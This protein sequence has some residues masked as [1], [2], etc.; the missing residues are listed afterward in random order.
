MKTLVLQLDRTEDA[1]SIRDKVAWG[2]AS[3]VLLVWPMNF[4]M[5]DRKFDLVAVKRICTTQGSRLGIICD[6]PAIITEA[7]ELQIP[8]FE[9]VNHAMR[10]AWDRRNRR[11]SGRPSV[12]REALDMDIEEL[13]KGKYSNREFWSIH[14]KSKIP[15]FLLAILAVFSIIIFLYPSAKITIFSLG[16]SSE[17]KIDFR[18]L[19][20]EGSDLTPGVLA[21]TKKTIKVDGETTIPTSGSLQVPDLKAGGVVTMTNLTSLDVSI[22]AGTIIQKP[23]NPPVRY[24]ILKMITIPAK[25]TTI[26]IGIE[27]I[28]PG[29]KG[30]S[31]INSITRLDG[32][33][34]LLVEVSN[35][36]PV[37]GGLEKTYQAV[38][39]DD[40]LRAAEENQKI[41][42]TQAEA[43]FTK[44]LSVQE[45][46]LPSSIHIVK[47]VEQSEHPG[48]EQVGVLL[49]LKQTVE[50]SVL[51]INQNDMEKQ[52]E[53]ILNVNQPV[54]GW[55]STMG[56]PV[57]IKILSQEFDME[58]GS[59]I[60]Q[61]AASKMFAPPLDTN[62]IR[63]Q[64]TGKSKAMAI[65]IIER[66]VLNIKSPEIEIMP[67]WLPF[68]PLLSSRIEIEVR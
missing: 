43:E 4:T 22:P 3:R 56:N 17:M 26:G 62:T 28:E 65:E 6:I 68:L 34:G 19:E 8:V 48:V 55:V 46:I 16:R 52:A 67:G 7:E 51:V 27:A 54:K 49:K 35:P 59:V 36:D 9:S 18:V 38:S 29:E 12:F 2:K 39:R 11:N 30:N 14:Q 23:S 61:T 44:I 64:T 25:E 32:P 1:G 33:L 40:I 15:V 47:V 24:Q 58:T 5:L 41:L 42:K 31:D 10:K 21:G 13:R 53:T 60:L 45:I 20:G 66:S 37:T 57:E 63:R 50:Y